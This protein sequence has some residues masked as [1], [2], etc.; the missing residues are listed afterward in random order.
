VCVSVFGSTP[1]A[2][3][4]IFYQR[5]PARVLFIIIIIFF[6]F[7]VLL[8]VLSSFA[9]SLLGGSLA[10]HNVFVSKKEIL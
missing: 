3:Q 1:H 7:F 9:S 8:L 2:K 6:F 10:D 5:N 4:V